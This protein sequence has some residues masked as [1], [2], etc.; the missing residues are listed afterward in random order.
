M[1]TRRVMTAR[2]S[3]IPTSSGCDRAQGHSQLRRVKT[4]VVRQRSITARMAGSLVSLR[5]ASLVT[6]AVCSAHSATTAAV[7]S[8]AAAN[9]R[10]GLFSSLL[11]PSSSHYG[12]RL[13]RREPELGHEPPPICGP[14]P[15]PLTPGEGELYCPG[16]RPP[17]TPRPPQPPPPPPPASP[18][19]AAAPA[20][21]RRYTTVTT[22]GPVLPLSQVQGVAPRTI[23]ARRDARAA[24]W[25]TGG[26]SPGPPG[27]PPARHR[28]P[29]GSGPRRPL[30]P[31]PRAAAPG[32]AW[33]AGRP[34]WPRAPRRWRRT[35]RRGAPGRCCPPARAARPGP[36]TGPGGWSLPA[37]TTRPPRSRTAGPGRT[38]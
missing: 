17:W 25:L 3:Q 13:T 5:N 2:L 31:T 11:T 37:T 4:T 34:T 15:G 8:Q 35:P 21:S 38:A 14:R 10:S 1:L 7:A 30:R 24:G 28:A 9:C 32:P 20:W 23:R 36:A 6:A 12:L 29:P 33:T 16:G 18:P 19:R 22:E 26:P 27:R